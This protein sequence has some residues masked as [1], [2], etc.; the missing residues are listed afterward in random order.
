MFMRS[1]KKNKKINGDLLGIHDMESGADDLIVLFHSEI[2]INEPFC[3]CHMIHFCFLKQPSST[4]CV[5]YPFRIFS[6]L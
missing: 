5:S 1:C 2:M 3:D 6:Y 4:I